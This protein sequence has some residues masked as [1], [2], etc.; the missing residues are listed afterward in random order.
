M[1][2]EIKRIDLK[3]FEG[4]DFPEVYEYIMTDPRYEYEVIL[5]KKYFNKKSPGDTFL[6]YCK[7]SLVGERL[8]DIADVFTYWVPTERAG[9]PFRFTVTISDVEEF[10][11]VIYEIVSSCINYYNIELCEKFEDKALDFYV[12]AV[13]QSINYACWGLLEVATDCWTRHQRHEKRLRLKALREE[14]IRKFPFFRKL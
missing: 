13:N 10:A 2:Q 9:D 14:W 5:E 11:D 3:R 8:V 1:K 6:N 7:A 4:Y 12:T